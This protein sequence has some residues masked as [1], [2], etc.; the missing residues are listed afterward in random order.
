MSSVTVQRIPRTMRT[1]AR[2][3]F[4]TLRAMRYPQRLAY[5]ATV[6]TYGRPMLRAFYWDTLPTHARRAVAG[7]ACAA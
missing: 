3:L 2:G 1:R 7:L 6:A 5:S 4:L